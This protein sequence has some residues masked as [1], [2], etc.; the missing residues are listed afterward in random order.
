[1]HPQLNDR[2][3][4]GDRELLEE[5]AGPAGGVVLEQLAPGDA[6][7]PGEDAQGEVVL[8]EEAAAGQGQGQDVALA[9]EEPFVADD[10]DEAQLVA[11]R[12]AQGVGPDAPFP[13]PLDGGLRNPLE[14][15]AAVDEEIAQP[16]LELPPCNRSR[17]A[18][19]G[20]GLLPTPGRRC[21]TPHANQPA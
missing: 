19:R 2:N 13:E 14:L 6:V 3:V 10:A 15:P 18:L 11:G 7:R 17:A 12:A 20:P 8:F 21:R 5:I 9:G 16:H 1:G 4:K